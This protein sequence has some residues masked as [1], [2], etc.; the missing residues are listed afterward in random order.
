LHPARRGGAATG[1]RDKG[2]RAARMEAR[3]RLPDA[4]SENGGGG[5]EPRA[6]RDLSMVDGDEVSGGTDVPSRSILAPG[7]GGAPRPI[8]EPD[9]GARVACPPATR[10][11][12]AYL[13]G[14]EVEPGPGDLGRAG[15]ADLLAGAVRPLDGSGV[16]EGIES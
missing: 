14:R 8:G 4:R 2:A 6:E 9:L 15:G 12:L 3:S 10:P 7:Q 13:G 11:R 1:R 16:P 5:P